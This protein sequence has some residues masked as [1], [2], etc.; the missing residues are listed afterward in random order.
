MDTPS[1]RAAATCEIPSNCRTSAI[2]WAN[3]AGGNLGTFGTSR[4][5]RTG[6][7]RATDCN[8]AEGPSYASS[9]VERSTSTST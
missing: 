7:G 1:C 4:T 8:G 2:H 6:A 3:E 5:G 9:G